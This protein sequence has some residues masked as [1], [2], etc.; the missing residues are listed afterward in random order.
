MAKPKPISPRPTKQLSL[1][2]DLASL[3][4]AWFRES[5]RALPWREQAKHTRRDPYAVLVSETMLQQTQVSRVLEKFGPFMQRFPTLQHLASAS[6]DQVL[7]AWTGLGYYRRA[8]KL[9]AAAK[10]IVQHHNGAV[11]SQLAQLRELPGVGAYTAGAV[12]SLAFNAPAAIVD[13]NVTRVLL[14]VQGQQI[15]DSRERERWVWQAAA[16]LAASGDKHGKAGTV[17]EAMMELGALVCTASSPRCE[18]CPWHAR[19]VARK[20][21]LI[22]VIPPP[23]Q[24]A[25]RTSITHVVFVVRAGGSRAVANLAVTRRASKGL[26]GGLWQ[27]PTLEIAEG[28]TDTALSLPRALALARAHHAE[29]QL[30]QT[31]PRIKA[32][33]AGTQKTKP[34]LDFVFCTTH[35]AVRHIVFEASTTH[36]EAF[37]WVSEPQALELGMASPQRR[38][39]REV[40]R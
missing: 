17:N 7:A 36:H 6:E 15:A 40:C 10:A 33:S 27:L 24:A 38:I 2:D 21:D 16:A 25:P 22:E 4:L 1:P 5:S 23:K 9:H 3:L 30:T 11:P 32:Q 13:T 28:D 29:W 34:L 12:A 35:R 39:V 14:R 18:S 26:W 31:S 20:H 37:L 8:R 19:C